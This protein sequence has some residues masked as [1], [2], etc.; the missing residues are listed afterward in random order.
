MTLGISQKLCLD[1]GFELRKRNT[2][3]VLGEILHER[4][5]LL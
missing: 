1:F 5:E 2:V 3:K 4:I